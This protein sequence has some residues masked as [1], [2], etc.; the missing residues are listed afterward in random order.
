[1]SRKYEKE[2]REAHETFWKQTPKTFDDVLKE[3]G[4]EWTK[5]PIPVKK[6]ESKERK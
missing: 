6:V 4:L 1:M 2:E 5:Y 3:L